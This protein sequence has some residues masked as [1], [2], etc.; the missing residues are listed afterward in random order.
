MGAWLAAAC[1]QR[2]IC[3]IDILPAMRHPARQFS[4]AGPQRRL[5]RLTDTVVASGAFRVAA[6]ALE[7][8]RDI[9]T[10]KAGSGPDQRRRHLPHPQSGGGGLCQWLAQPGGNWPTVRDFAA[11]RHGR[12]NYRNGLVGGR[13]FLA[14]AGADGSAA[15]V[16]FPDSMFKS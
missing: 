6:W 9:M 1:S 7:E 11:R 15:L 13:K 12:G 2:R 16:E 5:W 14:V 8:T 4:C 10:G 3:V